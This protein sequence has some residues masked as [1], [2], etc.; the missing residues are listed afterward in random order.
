MEDV[1]RQRN[2]DCWSSGPHISSMKTVFDY[3]RRRYFL[4]QWQSA[5]HFITRYPYNNT[6]VALGRQYLNVRFDS[7]TTTTM[8]MTDISVDYE[9]DPTSLQQCSGTP[10]GQ[11]SHAIGNAQPQASLAPYSPLRRQDSVLFAYKP[12]PMLAVI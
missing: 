12:Y 7:L 10:Q 1:P 11:L 6:D 2:I 8:S 5:S 3:F 4:R 9:T